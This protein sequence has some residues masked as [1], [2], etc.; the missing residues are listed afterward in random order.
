MLPKSCT[1]FSNVITGFV[2]VWAAT[3]PVSANMTRNEKI[4][5]IVDSNL[6]S[7]IFINF[8]HKITPFE[9]N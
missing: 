8:C 2:G 6:F 4:C 1:T 3:M 7:V 5:F 9:D